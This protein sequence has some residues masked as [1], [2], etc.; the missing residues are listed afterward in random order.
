MCKITRRLFTFR[1]LEIR[2]PNILTSIPM[3]VFLSP[4]FRGKAF[5]CSNFREGYISNFQT[6]SY[7]HHLQKYPQNTSDGPAGQIR[8]S[9]DGLT[10]ANAAKSGTGLEWRF[11]SR[12]YHLT[13][14]NV[15]PNQRRRGKGDWTICFD[16]APEGK[17]HRLSDPRLQL[18]CCSHLCTPTQQTSL[19]PWATT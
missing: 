6:S 12:Q 18:N 7:L 17:I 16:R 13:D 2:Q 10:G 19:C 14:S 1:F 3:S 15:F 9:R 5:E 4:P 11:Y 8:Q